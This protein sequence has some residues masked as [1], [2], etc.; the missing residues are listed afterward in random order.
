[1]DKPASQVDDAGGKPGGLQFDGNVSVVK[2]GCN[3]AVGSWMLRTVPE[4]VP[5]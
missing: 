2:S 4:S 3:E 5:E 1:M